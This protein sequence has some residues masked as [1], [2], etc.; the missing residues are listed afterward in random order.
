MRTLITAAV[1]AAAITGCS[2]PT[3]T[4]ATQS[5]TAQVTQWAS[6]GGAATLGAF[7]RD[8]ARYSAAATK[9]AAANSGTGPVPAGD[10][11]AVTVTAAAL[12]ADARAVQADPI[13]GCAA[14]A[15]TELNTAAG[16]YQR[17]AS[18]ITAGMAAYTAGHTAAA[19][20]SITAGDV[21]FT[22][23]D[24]AITAASASIRQTGS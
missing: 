18:D 21:A 8:M 3:A 12:I 9:F 19:T 1:T 5:C 11:T 15:R 24:D 23:A 17:G 16:A 14:S 20:A 7:T 2:A 10:V 6:H 4:P 13:P 22:A